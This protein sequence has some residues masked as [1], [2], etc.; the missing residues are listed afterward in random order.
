MAASSRPS[1]ADPVTAIAEERRGFDR[2]LTLLEAE[3]AALESG[4]VERLVA[5]AAEKS[6]IVRT[7]GELSERRAA[8]LATAGAPA[9]G[10][11]IA[12]WLARRADGPAARAHWEALLDSARRARDRN[13]RNGAVIDTRMRFNQAALAALQS[14]ARQA[15][16]YGRDGSPDV[17]TGGRTLGS[18]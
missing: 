3:A 5:L 17:P 6:G 16:V 4:D 13:D 14:A 7:L 11:A 10:A 18:A 15:T 2:F 9:G 1:A 8:A 12:D